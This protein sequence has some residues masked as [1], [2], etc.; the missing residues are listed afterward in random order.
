MVQSTLNLNETRLKNSQQFVDTARLWEIDE[1][2][3]QVSF[4]VV[5]LYP[6]VPIREAITILVERLKNN[7]NFISKLTFEE[8]EL[9]LN[10]CLSHCYFLYE[11]EIHELENSGPIGLALMVVIAECF[12]QYHESNALLSALNNNIQVKSFKRYVDDIHSRFQVEEDAHKFL[13]LLNKQHKSIQYT[14]ESADFTNTLNF[15]DISITNSK[16]GRYSFKIH[17][18]NAITNVQ[19]KPSSCHDPKIINGVFRGFVYRALR[20]CTT[21]NIDDEL[22][23]LIDVF[24]ENGYDR[25]NLE[26]LIKSTKKSVSNKKVLTKKQHSLASPK[27]FVSL[28]WIPGISPKLRTVFKNAG[29]APVFKSPKNLQNLLSSKNKPTLPV[30]SYPGIYKLECSCGKCYIGETGL[31][32][33]SRILQ[34]QT[35][36]QHG[37]GENSAVA[38]HSKTCQG[39]FLWNGRNT[40]KIEINSYNRKV[41]EALEIQHH[42]STFRDNGLNRDDGDYVTT[43]FWKPMFKF[44]RHK[45][46]S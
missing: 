42:E 13:N 19:I 16:T 23:F 28:P 27:S 35:S 5:N 2:E 46:L 29:Y 21:N 8:I 20:L 41:R 36:A 37:K 18:K 34:H 17:R 3:I 43:S 38:E 24:V 45:K 33:S 11:N 15:L 25:K 12:L 39:N 10:L 4:D 30:N 7:H 22:S 6:S 9:L 44:L 26:K 40:V 31:K 32:I 14:M 1:H